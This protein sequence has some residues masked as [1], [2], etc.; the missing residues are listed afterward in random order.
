MTINA[1]IVG[2]GWWGKH[3]MHQMAGSNALRFAAAVGT[4]DA[5]R[6]AADA[7]GVPF[8]TDFGPA[9]SSAKRTTVL[10]QGCRT[11]QEV[12]TTVAARMRRVQRIASWVSLI[13]Q[14]GTGT[15]MGRGFRPG[16]A[17][18]SRWLGSDQRYRR[19]LR[20]YVRKHT[21]VFVSRRM[22]VSC[23]GSFT[24]PRY[25]YPEVTSARGQ[26]QRTQSAWTSA[27]DER[28]TVPRRPPAFERTAAAR[29]RHVP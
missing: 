5:H 19:N 13:R 11:T 28:R 20:I 3:L 18:G 10:C 17:R 15:I 8:T 6:A 23:V 16:H 25:R 9:G 12:S 14:V 24:G 2:L 27:L 29:R 7:Y 4:R 22:Y 21:P 26:V 1:A